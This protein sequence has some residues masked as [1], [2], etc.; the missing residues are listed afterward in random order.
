MGPK[1]YGKE[2]FEELLDYCKDAV[3]LEDGMFSRRVPEDAGPDM[4]AKLT[5]EKRRERQRR[6]DAGDETARLK[7][8]PPQVIQKQKEAEAKV[9]AEEQR[10]KLEEA[11]KKAQEEA[12]KAAAA[13]AAAAAAGGGD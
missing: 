6:I 9:R 11:K 10:K 13:S 7:F 2:T 12:A 8:T 1:A 3:K 5:E 4:V